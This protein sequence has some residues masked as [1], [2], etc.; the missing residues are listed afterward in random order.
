ML[1][2][3]LAADAAAGCGCCCW[4]MPESTSVR[5]LLLLAAAAAGCPKTLARVASQSSWENT[6]FIWC[7]T[8][9]T[10]SNANVSVSPLARNDAGIARVFNRRLPLDLPLAADNVSQ[11]H[12]KPCRVMAA[13]LPSVSVAMSAG[14][15]GKIAR[16][17]ATATCM[18]RADGSGPW[19][20]MM[21]SVQK[22]PRQPRQRLFIQQLELPPAPLA[23][24]LCYR[25]YSSG[26]PARA[27]RLRF[28]LTEQ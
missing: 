16:F 28:K 9:G 21:N 3:W 12:C 14:M 24:G 1:I 15:G 26:R 6:T 11:R 2:C 5:L 27:K 19:N 18:Q 23:V 7:S 20:M 8:N 4:L 17:N 10:T 25:F 13:P 22:T